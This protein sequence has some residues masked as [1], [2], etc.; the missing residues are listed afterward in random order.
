MC[1]SD[2]TY[3]FLRSEDGEKFWRKM[4]LYKKLRDGV[5]KLKA[6]NAKELGYETGMMGPG[7]GEG[8]HGRRQN[9][10]TGDR[11]KQIC[12]HCGSETHLRRTSKECPKNPKHLQGEK[13]RG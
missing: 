7:R 6:D 11:P 1:D 4:T 13:Q 2:K 5:M 10:K 12:K 3:L 8:D 9:K